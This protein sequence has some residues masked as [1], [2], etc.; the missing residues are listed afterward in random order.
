MKTIRWGYQ[1]NLRATKT[2]DNINPPENTSGSVLPPQ[3][4]EDG[5]VEFPGLPYA[6]LVISFGGF[7]V[8]IAYHIIRAMF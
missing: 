6:V 8:W 3:Y 1:D 2:N 7:W 4:V 5:G